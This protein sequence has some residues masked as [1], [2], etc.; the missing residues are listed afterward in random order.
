MSL[1]SPEREQPPSEGPSTELRWEAEKKR[2]T[3][4]MTELRNT[5]GN[6]D[7]RARDNEI[8][9]KPVSTQLNLIKLMTQ[10]RNWHSKTGNKNE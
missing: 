6:D 2:K 7:D 9:E 3:D 8:N 5:Y 4:W 1:A 10:E